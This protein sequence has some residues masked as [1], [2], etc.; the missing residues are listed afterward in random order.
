MTRKLSGKQFTVWLLAGLTAIAALGYFAGNLAV[1]RV[2]DQFY[3]KETLAVELASQSVREALR[4]PASQLYSVVNL[5]PRMLQ[6]LNSRDGNL[7]EIENAFI[8]LL[9]RNPNYAQVR[10]ISEDGMEIVRVDQKRPG[11]VRAKEADALQDKSRRPYVQQGLQLQKD[12]L[13]VSPLDLNMENGEIQ[14]PYM[15]VVRMALR[16]YGNDGRPRG[17]IVL[18]IAAG[19][20]LDQVRNYSATENIMLLN[21]EGYWLKSANPA[22]E[23]GF[24]LGNTATMGTRHP[25]A[26]QKINTSASGYAETQSGLWTWQTIEASENHLSVAHNLELKLVAQ[27]SRENLTG[28]RLKALA[29][30]LITIAATAVFYAVALYR[31]MREMANRR[32]AEQQA[33]QANKAKGAF[34]ATMS[35]EIRTPMTGILG[36]A[37]MLLEDDLADDS[38]K[39]VGRI[40]GAAQA[41]LRILNDILDISKL[42]AGKFEIE[43]IPFRP[44][45]LANEVVQMFYQTCPPDKKD[46]LQITA[47]VSRSF[48]EVVCADPTRLRQVLVNLMG[49]AVKFSDRGSVTLVCDHNKARR[50]LEFEIIDTGIGMDEDMLNRLFQEF[51]QADATTSRKYH[52]TGLGLAICKKLV[53]RMG[54][55]IRARSTPGMGSA[56]WFSV[57]YDT[58]TTA[59]LP[60]EETSAPT[61]D[62]NQLA[63]SILVAEDNEINQMIIQNALKKL[64]HKAT[65][66]ESGKEA[67]RLMEEPNDFDLILMDVRM[68]E[69]SGPEAT[70]RIRALPGT[71]GIIPIIALTADVMEENKSAYF[72][73]GMNDCVGKPINQ[74]E[75]ASA[76][77]KAACEISI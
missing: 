1:K 59:D 46:T 55:D 13:Y 25:R 41:L 39:K 57:P 48:P 49:N 31:L 64:G 68:P 4:L 14:I 75:L 54:G 38:K 29:P 6:A 47:K 65:I 50:Q 22:D 7:S 35:H 70:R 40:K 73:A 17:L 62:A 15:P 58:A 53:E 67:L 9:L 19:P 28:A 8:T 33:N 61:V 43:K 10:W 36:F 5:E 69:M 24:M 12:Q 74:A 18:N 71:K 45:I 60:S 44:D 27:V 51:E 30:I 3:A 26:W 42:D 23:W 11:V 37:D 21:A 16:A 52:G 32:Y 56:F 72:E 76:I 2:D 63:L 20:M 66:A 77:N 34:L